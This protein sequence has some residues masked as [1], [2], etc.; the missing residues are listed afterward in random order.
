MEKLT[1][2]LRLLTAALGAFSA[3]MLAVKTINEVAGNTLVEELG[4]P[5]SKIA[6]AVAD[7]VRREISVDRLL[8]GMADEH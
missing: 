3:G 1:K 8:G 2:A 5:G 7:S 6:V 4:K